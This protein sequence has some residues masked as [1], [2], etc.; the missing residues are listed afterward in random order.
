M[1]PCTATANRAIPPAATP[2]KY[3][4]A[5]T[6]IQIAVGATATNG[7]VRRAICS[8]ASTRTAISTAAAALDPTSRHT[9]PAQPPPRSPIRSSQ[10]NVSSAPG[11]CPET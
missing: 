4:S 2:A 3:P 10:T 11:G 8:L 7:A 9:S 6:A 5:E 1:A